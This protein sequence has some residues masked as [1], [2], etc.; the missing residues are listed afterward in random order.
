MPQHPADVLD[1]LLSWYDVIYSAAS[2]AYG[3]QVCSVTRHLLSVRSIR[4]PSSERL[5]GRTVRIRYFAISLVE[6]LAIR[7]ASEHLLQN[8]TVQFLLESV[9]MMPSHWVKIDILRTRSMLWGCFFG[10]TDWYKKSRNKQP[11]GQ[12]TPLNN[13]K[14]I[15]CHCSAV[16][17]T[18]YCS[19]VP[20]RTTSANNTR[21]SSS[22]CVCVCVCTCIHVCVHVCAHSVYPYIP[23]TERH[24]F[25]Y[26]SQLT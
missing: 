25:L 3:T 16:S 8:D 21:D 23:D 6:I 26:M 5:L 13:I 9:S 11:C 18:S 10:K 12:Q 7:V 17:L 4:R 22:V 2:G 19:L 15:W 24:E 1:P 20:T 14:I